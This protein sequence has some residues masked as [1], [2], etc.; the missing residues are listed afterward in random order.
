MRDY[1]RQRCYDWQF[2]ALPI[3]NKT[4]VPYSQIQQ[5]VDYVWAQEGQ[6][7]PPRVTP[8]HGN[9]TATGGLATRLEVQFPGGR[10]KTKL[11]M[12]LH[13]LAHSLNE[14]ADG[15]CRG[16]DHGPEFVGLFMQLLNRHAMIPMPYLMVTANN[17]KLH[18]NLNVEPV[19]VD[20]PVLSVVEPKMAATTTRKKRK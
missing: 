7:H 20:K 9:A 1:Q 5:I 14:D 3:Y 12:I 17:H 19:V 13:E 6:Q 15:N 2:D 10:K 11:W 16:A 18:Y 8:L 4:S